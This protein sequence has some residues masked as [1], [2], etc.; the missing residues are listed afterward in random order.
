MS[1]EEIIEQIEKSFTEYKGTNQAIDDAA[2]YI[3][4]EFDKLKKLN[5][6]VKVTDDMPK[7]GIDK[8]FPNC[9]EF[10][11]TTDCITVNYS[12]FEEGEWC[13]AKA[14]EPYKKSFKPKYWMSIADT[15]PVS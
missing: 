3:A 9:S 4:D 5:S 10:V 12:Y 11:L 8:N 6:W 13:C 15:L 7:I 2:F 14:D 1:K